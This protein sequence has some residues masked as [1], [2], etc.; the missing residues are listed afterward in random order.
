MA[1]EIKQWLKPEEYKH[2]I[3]TQKQMKDV[4]SYSGWAKDMK[5]RL[6]ALER[7]AECR[8]LMGEFMEA[9]ENGSLSLAINT[10]T[11]FSLREWIDK[12][13]QAIDTGRK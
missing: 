8:R 6:A 13:T 1:N 12:V 3:E 9:I 7:L 10:Q 4:S 11:D 5:I 2:Y